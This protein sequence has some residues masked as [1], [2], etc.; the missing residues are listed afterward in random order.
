MKN[1][2]T[3]R[4]TFSSLE[5]ILQIF[6]YLFSLGEMFIPQEYMVGGID[7][8]YKPFDKSMLEKEIQP[9]FVSK[10]FII[11]DFLTD[12]KKKY[13]H[14]TL[15]N[16]DKYELKFDIINAGDHDFLENLTEFYDFCIEKLEPESGFAH[17]FEDAKKSF[18]GI[19]EKIISKI[20]WINIYGDK[21]CNNI[22][23]ID[24]IKTL[25]LYS[26]KLYNGN[27]KILVIRTC[28][29]PRDISSSRFPIIAQDLSI[30]LSKNKKITIQT[31]EKRKFDTIN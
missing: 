12:N 24:E 3:F 21:I 11:F 29:S 19:K 22:E 4:I 28:E 26:T 7:D 30:I 23:N 8:D 31:P 17:D 10:D 9:L 2:I 18:L 1:V 14:L 6:K 16:D 27:G 20:Y 13:F 25:N 15:K 5:N